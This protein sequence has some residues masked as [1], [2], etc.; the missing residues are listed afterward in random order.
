[1][2]LYVI[3]TGRHKSPLKLK[4]ER[5]INQ[6]AISIKIDSLFSA[7]RTLLLRRVDRC[8][9]ACREESAFTSQRHLRHKGV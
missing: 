6:T 3:S 4:R 9:V 5:Q 1:M 2:S 7:K 8:E